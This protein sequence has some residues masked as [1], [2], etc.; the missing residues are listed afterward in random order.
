MNILFMGTPHFASASLEALVDAGHN[1]VGVVTRPDK[2]TGRGRK[3]TAPPVKDTAQRHGLPVIQPTK[4]NSGESVAVLA[5]LNPSVVVVVAFGAILR[6]PLLTLAPMG[7]VNVHASVLPAYRGVA[8]VQWGLI[9]G[10]TTAGVTTMLMDEG[11]DTGPTLDRRLTDVNPGET[12][13]ELLTRLADLGA[14]LLVDTIR[15]LEEGNL[16]PIPQSDIG[17]SYAPR[18]EREHGYL[19]LTR[20]ASEVFSNR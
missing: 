9:H 16:K 12:S 17:A 1:L 10:D 8:P 14:T 20:S 19:D 2:P 5:A 4:V 11:V 7:A 15:G 6:R 13:G 18:L 3:L